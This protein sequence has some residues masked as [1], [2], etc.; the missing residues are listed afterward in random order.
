MAGNHTEIAKFPSKECQ[1]YQNVLG[2]LRRWI[3][4]LPQS[5]SNVPPTAL[6]PRVIPTPIRQS[7]QGEWSTGFSP[8]ISSN[9]AAGPGITE[10]MNSSYSHQESPKV[11]Q[12]GAPGTIRCSNN[13][14]SANRSQVAPAQIPWQPAPP[15][16]YTGSAPPAMPTWSPWANEQQSQPMLTDGD[17]QV[18][19]LTAKQ[20]FTGQITFNNPTFNL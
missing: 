6:Q 5:A 7:F 16:P 4:Q 15:F 17:V 9:G 8:S 14:Q 20:A 12:W 3:S 19:Q 1:G 2:E 13:T 18:G 11:Q 10:L